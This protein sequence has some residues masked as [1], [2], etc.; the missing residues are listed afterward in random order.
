MLRY[1]VGRIAAVVPIV[2][3][4]ATFVF[5]L[6]HVIPESPAALMLGD[7]A[8]AAQIAHLTRALGLD[9]PLVVQYVAWLGQVFLHGNLGQSLYYQQ[10]VT[11]VLIQHAEPTALLALGGLTVAVGIGIPL[12]LEAAL[13]HDTMIDRAAMVLAVLGMSVPTFWLGLLLILVFS[14][15]LHILPVGGF[16]TFSQGGIGALRFLVM[17]AFAIGIASSA[18]IA[19]MTRGAT[20][21]VMNMLYV[22]TARAKGL[23]ERVVTMK[24]IF[25]NAMI[26]TLTVIGLIVA[27]LF[28]GAIVIETVF[29]IAGAG[30]LM[31]NSVKDLDYPVI[32]GAVMMVAVFYVLINLA[33]DMV[34]AA[35]DPR[36]R[37]E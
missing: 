11:T 2:L 25:K 37:Y 21:D 34:Y 18:L 30:S 19:R 35:L 24:H 28:S 29:T 15:T 36:V 8:T 4:V 26:P 31:I 1:A 27:D 22:R 9:R 6:T 12:G 20:L 17:P 7:Q 33:T 5:V 32:Q 14:A 23:P 16:E 3:L 10:P 13:H